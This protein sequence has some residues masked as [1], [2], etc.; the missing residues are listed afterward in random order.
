MGSSDSVATVRENPISV[1]V[2]PSDSISNSNTIPV[3]IFIIGITDTI[4]NKSLFI[5][6]IRF[7]MIIIT[8]S[9][10]INIIIVLIIV[11]IIFI[12]TSTT[13]NFSNVSIIISFLSLFSVSN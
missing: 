13:R 6:F 5:I 10:T 11:V 7:I 3:I 8:T 9:I 12:V 2:A 4:I 1:L